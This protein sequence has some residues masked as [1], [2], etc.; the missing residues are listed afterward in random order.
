[1]TREE[2]SKKIRWARIIWVMGII[3]VAAMLPQLYTI[4][5]THKTDNLSVEMFA[6]YFFVQV[7]FSLEGYFI[8]NRMLM[9]CLGLSAVVSASIIGLIFCF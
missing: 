9:T 3:N 8:R 7:S 5:K 4:L 6:I 1:M 2:F